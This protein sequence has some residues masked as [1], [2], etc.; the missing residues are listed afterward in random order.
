[1]TFYVVFFDDDTSDTFSVTFMATEEYRKAHGGRSNKE[2]VLE[3]ARQKYKGRKIIKIA[4]K[5]SGEVVYEAHPEVC[6]DE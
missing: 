3:Y 1:M 6:A 5:T 4:R 2:I